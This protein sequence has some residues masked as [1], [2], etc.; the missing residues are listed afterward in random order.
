MTVKLMISNVKRNLGK[1]ALAAGTLVTIILV[2]ISFLLIAGTIGRFM[3][4]MDDSQAEILC[5]DSI[6]L[7]ANTI[8]NINPERASEDWIH[9]QLKMAPPLCKTIDRKISGERE[10]IM[11]QVADKMVRCWQMFGEGQYDEILHNSQFGLWLYNL[12][13]TENKCFLCYTQL[14]E[15]EDFEP[16]KSE[17]FLQFLVETDYPKAKDI[18]YIDYIQHHGG[19]GR[20]MILENIEPRQAYGISFL[21]KNKD[22]EADLWGGL[23]KTAG[24]IGGVVGAAKLVAFGI[25]VAGGVAACTASVVCAV[26]V[27]GGGVLTVGSYI[28]GTAGLEDLRAIAKEAFD[29]TDRDVSTITFSS[30]DTAQEKCFRG[31]LAGE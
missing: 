25:G 7:R 24:A 27:V 30:L 1:K 20:V 13:E 16:I 18:K 12:D 3:A 23:G 5:Q 9:G 8:I 4:K 22:I 26:A 29:P 14:I 28:L 31:D 17:E 19:P 21:A 15:E 6:A 10:E 11:Q 2:V